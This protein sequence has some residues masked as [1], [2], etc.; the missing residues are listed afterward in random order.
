MVSTGGRRKGVHM[1]TLLFHTPQH[2]HGLAHMENAS[3][4]EPSINPSLSVYSCFSVHVAG[5][6]V[7]LVA[8]LPLTPGAY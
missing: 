4:L 2:S 1:F 8:S 5:E 3:F 6:L 7:D